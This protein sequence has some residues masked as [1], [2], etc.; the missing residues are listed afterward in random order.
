MNEKEVKVEETL[1]EFTDPLSNYTMMQ[2]LGSKLSN[3]FTGN[4]NRK[5]TKRIITKVEKAKYYM[6]L[7]E[8]CSLTT[9][10]EKITNGSQTVENFVDNMLNL[11][12]ILNTYD[13]QSNTM[14]EE[15]SYVVKQ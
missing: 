12:T 13:N 7:D 2:T 3:F 5:S 8:L 11:S 4:K 6:P 10:L 1:I 14:I 15:F 9:V